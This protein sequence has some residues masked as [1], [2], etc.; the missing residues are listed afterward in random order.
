[1]KK[2][3]IDLGTNTFNLLVFEEI[4]DEIKIVYTAR[5]PVGL[6]MGGINENIIAPDAFERGLNTINQFKA[7]CDKYRVNQ[8][9]AFGTSALRGAKNGFEF[10]AA[11]F[12]SSKIDIEIIDGKR[13][14]ELIYKGVQL[15][16]NFKEKSCI[17]DIGGGSTEFIIVEEVKMADLQSFDIG[18]A[19]ILQLFDFSDPLTKD[20]LAVIEHFFKEKTSSFF[21]N[22][23]SNVLIGASG[24]FETFYELI[25]NKSYDNEW[26]SV[27][28]PFDSLLNFLDELI[29][30]SQKERDENEKISDLRKNMIHIAAFKTKWVIEQLNIKEVWLSPASLKEGVIAEV[31]D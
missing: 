28:L 24:S 27:Q 9:K 26:E 11:I 4:N 16:H 17:M 7:I 13:E 20:D 10:K 6:G 12:K 14:A 25:M 8:I 18:V 15:V 30:S 5:I 2:A 3:V 19:R 29:F 23:S 22:Q 21:V 1:M 31:I